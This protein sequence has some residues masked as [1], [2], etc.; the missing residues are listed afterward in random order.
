MGDPFGFVYLAM[1][2]DRKGDL[3]PEELVEHQATTCRS[4]GVDRLREVDV[5][6]GGVPVEQSEP[7]DDLRR[8]R[9][10]HRPR[11][12]E[13]GVDRSSQVPGP[14]PPDRGVYRHHP[15]R[16]QRL[17]RPIE[18]VGVGRLHLQRAPV[19]GDRP[20]QGHLRPLRQLTLAEGLVEPHRL[21]D[22]GPVGDRRL[23]DDQP[24]SWASHGDGADGADD[25]DL[26]LERHLGE[27]DGPAPV[28]VAAR[29]VQQQVGDRGH[30]CR[31]QLLSP[32]AAQPLDPLDADRGQLGQRVAAHST[33]NRYG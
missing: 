14:D 2:A 16:D 33:P 28:D 7:L 11:L 21:E 29:H 17:R 12:E 23:D 30:P 24:A 25:R 20:R 6:D 31:P 19:A 18:D 13:C 15:A 8:D 4:N 5:A 32:L 1:L 27:R 9:I 26:L 10:G 3:E 22:P